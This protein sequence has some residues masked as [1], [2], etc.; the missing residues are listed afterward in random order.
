MVNDMHCCE[1]DC[2]KPAEFEIQEDRTDI[3]PADGATHACTQH[4]GELLGTAYPKEGKPET[5][6]WILSVLD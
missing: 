4:V 3:H 5:V 1:H 6:R 2:G